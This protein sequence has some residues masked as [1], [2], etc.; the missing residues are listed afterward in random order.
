MTETDSAGCFNQD[1][2]LECLRK[3]K[4]ANDLKIP[5]HSITAE[6]A[7]V[8]GLMLDA[9]RFDDLI[10]IVTA[11]DFYNP[12]YKLIFNAIARLCEQNS[13]IDVVTVSNFL[14]SENNLLKIGGLAAL[15]RLAN[16]T[17]SAANVVHYA[18]IVRDRSILRQLVKVGGEVVD[19]AFDKRVKSSAEALNTAEAKVLAIA[20]SH[21]VA[22]GCL[23]PLPLHSMIDKIQDKFESGDVFSGLKT[24]FVDLDDRI[25]GLEPGDFFIIAGRPS[26]GKT[27]LAMNIASNIAL[28]QKKV[29]VFSLEMPGD[30]LTFR[31]TSSLSKILFKRLR[32]GQLLEDD[33]PKLTTAINSLN[34]ICL[35]IDDTPALSC[36]DMRSHLRRFV[37]EHE[38]VDLIVIDYLQLMTGE[39]ENRTN[40][41]SSI[42]RGV[43]ALAKEFHAPVIALSQL[44]R[45]VESRG[46]KRPRMADLR[47]SGS[48]E[49]DAD[50][51]LFVYRDEVY[52]KDSHDKGI[53][54][55]ITGK[56]RNGEIGTDRLTF[57]GQ[58][59]SFE[60]LIDGGGGGYE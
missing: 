21:A 55:I 18:Q 57:L 49:Q 6:Q 2:V 41:V 14:E 29:A 38:G 34:S 13:P 44:N 48:L 24:G 17:P 36:A 4:H 37:R 45:E 11:D 3:T 47:D 59:C 16:D 8:G 27:S 10:G 20:D 5:P 56:L 30:M 39:G 32:T 46:D 53:A 43:K 26:M 58:Y 50:G 28:Q 23:M 19:L 60:N 25:L 35:K 40:E 15:G 54:E 7:V 31:L 51:V 42:S 33:W 52:D 22:E 1:C 12:D 9:S